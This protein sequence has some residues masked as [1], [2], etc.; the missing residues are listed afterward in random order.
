VLFR[1]LM[2]NHSHFKTNAFL[3]CN[4]GHNKRYSNDIRTVNDLLV[5]VVIDRFLA[6]KMNMH[7]LICNSAEVKFCLGL[8]NPQPERR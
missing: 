8:T 5:C 3:P 6:D 7:R 2:Q 1:S 4:Q